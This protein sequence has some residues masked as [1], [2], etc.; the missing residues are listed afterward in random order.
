[1]N[2]VDRTEIA[3]TKHFC[4]P[5]I[6]HLFGVVEEGPNSFII[7]ELAS[8]GS[9]DKFLRLSEDDLP[10]ELFLRWIKQS[11]EAVGYL[12]EQGIVHRDI[13]SPNYLITGK[14]SLMS[15]YVIIRE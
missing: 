13:K 11:V 6:V 9:L 7:M 12:H 14:L 1:M 8:N 5:N 4:H 15:S 2:E 3:L 10:D